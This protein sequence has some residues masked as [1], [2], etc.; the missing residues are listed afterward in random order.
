[1]CRKER[2]A[3][4]AVLHVPVAWAY[5]R[6]GAVFRMADFQ[7]Q[8]LGPD[9]EPDFMALCEGSDSWSLSPLSNQPYGLSSSS[10]N[11]QDLVS[12]YTQLSH[13]TYQA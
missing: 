3:V 13:V 2:G 7:F 4:L 5:A 9:L 6:G 8:G 10:G 12:S 11:W 1:M